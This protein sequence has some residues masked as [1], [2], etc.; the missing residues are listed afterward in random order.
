MDDAA[1]Y[2]RQSGDKTAAEMRPNQHCIRLP[3]LDFESYFLSANTS[4]ALQAIASS[5]AGTPYISVC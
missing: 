4:R 5:V 3:R 2:L 1:R